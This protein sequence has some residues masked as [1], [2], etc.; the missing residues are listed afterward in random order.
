MRRNALACFWKTE[1]CFQCC[2]NLEVSPLVCVSCFVIAWVSAVLL[3][4][5]LRLRGDGGCWMK[6]HWNLR[7]FRSD[8]S[9]SDLLLDGNIVKRGAN[10]NILH[11]VHLSK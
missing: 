5:Y 11:A 1:L 9:R 6:T 7:A 3:S 10:F 4:F 8:N 2:L